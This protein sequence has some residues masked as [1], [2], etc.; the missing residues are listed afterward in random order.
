MTSIQKN[1]IIILTIILASLLAVA[2]YFGA[3][4][5]STYERDAVSMAA[6]G[7][8]QDFVDLFLIVPLL[9]I[10]LPFLKNVSR[11][12]LLIHAGT[13]FYVLYS[14]II[15]AF[16]VHFNRLFLLY[17]FIL[18]L[19]LYLFI[20]LIKLLSDLDVHDWFMDKMP[21]RSISSFLILIAVMFYLLWFKDIIPA[22]FNNTVPKS[23]SDY[24]LLVNPVHVIDIAFALPGLLI[25]AILLIKKHK[26]GYIFTAVA[27]EFIILLTIAL[28][29]MV[30]SLKLKGI[31]DD[32]SIAFIFTGLS[33]IGVVFFLLFIKNIK[34]L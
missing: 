29:G 17:C 31:S 15:Y 14:F 6:Q 9:L 8:G 33:V 32:I 12:I 10:V 30:V 5:T 34:R 16:G 24:N 1:T 19:S 22:I 2:S 13:A 26:L 3:F 7:I 23:V 28:I 20:Y 18:G 25:T 4:V 11:V 27:L 21:V